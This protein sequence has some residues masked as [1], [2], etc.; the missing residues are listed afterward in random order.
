[1]P[2]Q[3]AA[4]TG[5]LEPARLR[6]IGA[7]RITILW[8]VILVSSSAGAWY[9]GSARDSTVDLSKKVSPFSAVDLAVVAYSK[10]GKVATFTRNADGKLERDGQAMAPQPTPVTAAS[11]GAT[12]A[13]P[14]VSIA[15]GSRVESFANQL[16]DLPVDRVVASTPST[17]SEYG[18]DSPVLTIEMTAKAGGTI[19]L[20]FGAK[21]VGD[22]AY[23]VRR[24]TRDTNDTIL[25]S[26]YT[27]DEIL[28]FAS[29]QLGPP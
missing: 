23:Y 11:T 5:A 13:I 9:F 7:L 8:V 18:L 27:I 17:S 4:T 14:T 28:K 1:M 26:R 2:R 22:G 12:P 3:R 15:P 29:D 6:R 16:R 25:A 21:A 10:D 20:A 19:R 24:E